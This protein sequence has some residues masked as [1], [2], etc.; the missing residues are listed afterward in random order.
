MWPLVAWQPPAW[1][2]LLAWPFAAA[3]CLYGTVE[4]LV[5]LAGWVSGK[6]W[7]V[8]VCGCADPVVIDPR[9][10]V[11]STCFRC[12]LEWVPGFSVDVLPGLAP[13]SP[14]PDA[15]AATAPPGGVAG[16]GTPSPANQRSDP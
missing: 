5:K 16:P 2:P 15:D 9:P 12:G 4:A 6:P 7:C 8:V 13:G 3:A 11:S 1:L 14:R 10:D